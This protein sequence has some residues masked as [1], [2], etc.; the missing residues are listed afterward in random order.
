M[1]TAFPLLHQYK[2][3]FYFIP[4]YLIFYSAFSEDPFDFPDVFHLHIVYV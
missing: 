4:Q 1:L 2:T 3:D